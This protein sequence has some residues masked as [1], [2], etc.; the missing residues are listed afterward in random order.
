MRPYQITFDWNRLLSYSID[1][2]PNS[3]QVLSF[4]V[5][6]QNMTAKVGDVVVI[7]CVGGGSPSFFVEWNRI[8]SQ[9]F[10][11]TAEVLSTGALVF[12]PVTLEDVGRYHCRVSNGQEELQ[13][14]V[15]LEVDGQLPFL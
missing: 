3:S 10:P 13:A 11:H 1:M 8:H 6:P 14:Y 5:T 2:Q 9:H 12:D 15:S 7:E 4:L